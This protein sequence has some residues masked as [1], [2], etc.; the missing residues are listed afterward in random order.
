MTNVTEPA[1]MG[2]PSRPTDRHGR[3]RIIIILVA[4]IGVIAVVL[5]GGALA[6]AKQFEGRALPGTTV[7]G[8]DVA[9]KTP[10]EIAALV[11]ERG[12]GVTVTVTAGDQ[13]L[14]VP[15]AD[16]GVSVDA[17]AT[18]QAAVDG[19]DSFGDVISSTWSGER[20]VEPV[21]SVDE[22]AVADFA[23]GLIPED[24]TEP[25]DAQVT[26]DEEAQTWNAEP[27]RNGQG[28]D[29]ETLV[30]T[31]KQKA[32]ALEDFSVEQPIQD[33]APAITTAE[34]EETVG[35]IGSLLEQPMSIAGAED[36]THEVSAERRS[37]WL[38]VAPDEEGKALVVSVDEDAVHEWVSARADEDAVEVKNGI[39]QVDEEGE[40]VK[41]VAEKTDGLQI[42]N[43]DAVAEEL[44]SAL[45]GTSP[46]EAAFETKK[47]EAE[48]D[49]VDAPKDEDEEK[50]DEKKKDEEK[51]DADEKKKDEE[52]KDADEKKKDAEEETPAA[53]PTGEKWID[54]DLANKTVTAYVGD[55]PVWGPRSMVDGKEGNE[56]VTG[57][58]EIYLRYD[59]QDM[60]NAAYYPEGHEKYYLT[61]DVPWVQYFH[62]GFGF[63]G[64]PW[65]S[66]F[67]F[68]GSHGCINMPVSDAKWLYDWASMG[69]RVESHY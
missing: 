37:S 58:F 38:S 45:N 11:T 39:E 29:P 56:T 53:K 13:Q 26:F 35:T 12:E 1:A 50:K 46:L 36:E 40:V 61:K 54:V 9:G 25:V 42:T 3:R 62:R 63:H 4:I 5:T 14:E 2:G 66:S 55:T 59:R 7:L 44:I 57:S 23:T 28:V 49:E 67:G 15:L 18:A 27:G 52:K 69:T 24:M 30:E 68:S 43:T 48:V 31:V 41:V 17:A 34:A 16:L 21:V 22:T 19:E 64:A 60:T 6:Y 47:V 65:R 32:P 10:E 51:K 33:I 20:A 8:Q